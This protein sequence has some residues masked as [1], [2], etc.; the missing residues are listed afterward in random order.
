M[1]FRFVTTGVRP[2]YWFVPHAYGFGATPATV[3]GWVATA[4]YLLAIGVAVKTMPTD[5]ARMAL[6]A[7]ITIGYLFVLAIK[8]DGGLGWRWGGK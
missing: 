5:G 2:G 6:G 8:T 7:G 1:A 3:M 4:A